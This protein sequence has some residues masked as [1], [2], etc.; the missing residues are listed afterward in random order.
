MRNMKMQESPEDYL[1]AIYMLSLKQQEVRSIDIARHLGYSKPSVSVAMKRLR[2]NGFVLMDD[3]GFL[4]LTPEGRAIATRVYERHEVI[5]RYLISI[6]INEETAQKDA[7]RME[8]VISEETFQK[9][10]ELYKQTRV[11]ADSVNH[12]GTRL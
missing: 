4:T 11:A 10:K 6:G 12:R 1:E 7:C 3:N 8:H 5:S 2:E 9:I